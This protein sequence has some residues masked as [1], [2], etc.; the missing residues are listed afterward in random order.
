MST[1]GEFSVRAAEAA[2]A[3]TLWPILRAVIRPG[4]TYAVDPAM[5][6]AE[7]SSWWME[8]PRETFVPGHGGTVLD[9]YH[10]RTNQGGGGA[11]V[12]N[13][14][15]VVAPAARGQGIARA[16]CLHSLG[17]A[18]ALGYRAMQFNCVVATNTGAIRLWTSLGFE[19]VGRLPSA[20][21]HPRVGLV[22]AL[23]MYKW[24]CSEA[25]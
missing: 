17:V 20:F 9:S 22:D 24:L 18:R 16:M 23:V 15:Y 13:C 19:T 14:G 12:C 2:D 4:D 21:A 6:R 5:T 10:I 3:E 25:R 11:H 1:A 7:A 8:A